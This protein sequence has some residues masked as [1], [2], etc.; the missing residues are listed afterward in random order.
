M[1][2]S[3]LY[4]TCRDC[5]QQVV[6]AGCGASTVLIATVLKQQGSGSVI[7][8]EHDA[9]QV[10]A[11]RRQL[12]L[13]NLEVQVTV[14][15]APLVQHSIGEESWLWYDLSPLDE[16]L[17]NDTPIDLLLI[18][19]PPIWTQPLARYPARPLL[20]HRLRTPGG[21]ILLDD[22]NRVSEQRVLRRW[23]DESPRWDW[24]NV[25]TED[26]LAIGIVQSHEAQACV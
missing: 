4:S 13:L 1:R 17:P 9:R 20:A 12:Q 15:H 6:E 23:R 25:S 10:A 18:D 5:A 21:V 26:G 24:S 11:C 3:S 22:A 16:E 19:G 7:A 8:L 2:P 14:L